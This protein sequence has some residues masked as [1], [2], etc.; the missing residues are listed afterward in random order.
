MPVSHRG[1]KH[2]AERSFCGLFTKEE[3]FLALLLTVCSCCHG[4]IYATLL[5][6]LSLRAASALL[7]SSLF[8]FCSLFSFCNIKAL[9]CMIR[10]SSARK[11]RDR[12]AL[13]WMHIRFT[14]TAK[15]R[16]CENREYP[17]GRQDNKDMQ[18]PANAKII[19][20]QGFM[21]GYMPQL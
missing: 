21:G 4:S 5:E 10:R 15:D 2:I 7:L 18:E 19:M 20:T 16:E 6:K 1:H 9:S 14:L 17:T 8:P 3:H 11:Q 12:G 13:R